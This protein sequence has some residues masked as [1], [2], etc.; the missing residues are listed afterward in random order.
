MIFIDDITA[1]VVYL[2]LDP[3]L[4]SISD[5]GSRKQEALISHCTGPGSH[6]SH[7]KLGSFNLKEVNNS[8]Y[9]F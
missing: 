5:A 6:V 8:P 2:R 9:G 3:Q 4:G 7:F 1:A